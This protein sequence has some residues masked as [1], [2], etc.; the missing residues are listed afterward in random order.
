MDKKEL[1]NKSKAMSYLL[2]HDP[3]DLEMNKRGWVLIDDLLDHLGMDMVDL[4]EVVGNNDKQRFGFD[5]EMMYIRANQG[6]SIKWVKIDMETARP[7]EC[8]YHGTGEKTRDIILK[9]G[10]KSMNREYVHLSSDIETAT[11]VGSRHGKPIIFEVDAR[12]MYADGI[13]FKISKN[14]VWQVEFVD[15]IYLTILD[16]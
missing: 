5:E 7:M 8:L 9:T 13:V 6:H 2:R 10:V 3:K 1:K 14:G 15:P 11:S 4:E 12:R 16:I